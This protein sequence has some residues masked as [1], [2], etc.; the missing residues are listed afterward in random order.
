M[1]EERGMIPYLEET[2]DVV[3][4]GAGHAGCEAALAS[5]R[6]G[7]ETIMFTVSVD[8]IALMPCNPNIGGSSK[9]HLVR[10]LDALGG[11]MGKNID[12]TFIQ[13]KMLNES[14][15]P[16]VHSLRAQADKQDYSRHMRKTL[17]NTEHLTIRQAE[18]SEIMAEDGKIRGVKTFS[19]AVYYA[20]AVIL[21][22]G[23]Y[24]KARCIYGDVSNPT[25]PNGLQAANHLT[26]SLR[27]HGI[28]MF[29][30][31]TGTPA[32]V[33]KKSIDFSK[34]EEQFG[35]PRVVP[36]SFSTNPDEI[37]KDQVSCWL[38]YTNENT[39][40]IIKD[41]LDRSPL[42]S[43]A[44]EGTG[45]RY[46]PSIEDK[47]VKFPDKN[48]HQVFVEPEGLYTNEMYLGGMSSSLPEDVQYAMYRTVPGLEKVKIV[49]NAYAIEYDCINALQLKPTL[50]F[51]KISGL[52]AGGQFNG[53][54]GYEEAAVQGF[55]AGV[56]AVMK[57]RGQEAVVLDRSQAY[58][59]VLIDDL[60][61]KENHE[62]Y[63][64]MTS[65]AEYRLLLRQD[66]ADIRLRK[67]GHEIGLVSDEE[68]EHLLKKMDDIQS[69]IKRLEKTVIGVSDRVQMFLGKY[70]STLLKSGITLAEL[71]KRPELDYVKLAK[72][73]EGRPELP[74]DVTE[75]VNIEIKYEG[76]IKRQMQQVAQ[77]KKLEDKKLPEDF[78]YSEVN[79]L[80]REAVQKLN[81]VQPATIGQAS[82]IS[83]VSP[84]D[85]SVLLVHFTRKQ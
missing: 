45:P 71:V 28:E 4:V 25:G 34:M 57:I 65:R 72:L 21:C 51:K 64:M 61:T 44:I 80:R 47:V 56:N 17:E 42:F 37:Q 55:M 31:K 30:F 22:T 85:I 78:D 50:E 15:G 7:M 6:L 81:K 75:Q 12:K 58:I 24:L 20:K 63:R 29:R 35:D 62:P 46:C 76:Y 69:E 41:N 3:I 53:S 74:D 33:D 32:R 49:R 39:H 8:S 83:G 67:I 18:V 38:T 26:D 68:Y 43:G 79:S 40:R 66:N 54:S 60:V 19:G 11:E 82:R 27:K 73:D 16:A 5:A 23:T 2:Y 70:G 59:G 9:G 77:F 48:R 36:F 1:E 14:K 13:S 84:A 10:E 52:F